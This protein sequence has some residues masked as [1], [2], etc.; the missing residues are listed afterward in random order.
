MNERPQVKRVHV[1]RAGGRGPGGNE[2]QW[3]DCVAVNR[4]VFSITGDW[5]TAARDPGVL[6]S[7]VCKGGSRFMAAWVREEEKS[8][9]NRQRKTDKVEV[10]G[11]RRKLETFQSR[12]DRTD[13]RTPEAASAGPIGKPENPESVVLYCTSICC[14]FV[15]RFEVAAIRGGHRMA[16]CQTLSSECP[17]VFCARTSCICFIHRI[18]LRPTFPI[19]VVAFPPLFFFSCLV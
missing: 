8:S 15:C 6:Y 11:D 17:S 1:G 16:I 13:P 10:A 12:V 19:T 3:M 7:T 5:S 18:P 4:R 9:G 14:A 2:K